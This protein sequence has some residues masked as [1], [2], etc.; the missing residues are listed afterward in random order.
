MSILD[1]FCSVDDF[2]QEF[3]PQWERHLLTQGRQRQRQGEMC[4][5]EML[6]ILI[7]FHFSGMRNFKQY[8]TQYVA[9]WLR[10]EFPIQLSYSRLLQV[11]PSLLTP[12]TVYLSQQM[13][14]CTGLNF[15]DSTSLA[16]C[17][18]ARIA[19]H[20]VFATQAARGKTSIGW[21]FGFKLHLV[22]NDQGE[23]LAFRLTPGNCDDRR[24]VPHLLQGLFGKVFADKGYISQSLREDLWRHGLQ[25]ITRV[26]KNMG[27]ILMDL[28]DK[29]LLRKRALIESVYDHL[30]NLCQ[31]EHTRH[32]SPVNFLVNLVCGLIAYSHLPHKP[33]LHIDH[34]PVWSL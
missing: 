8:Y 10:R 28:T 12:L 19:A 14:T 29:L 31:I 13:G 15:L 20:R 9:H 7:Y 21:F 16:V 1:L 30:K 26:R 23:L 27:N 3:A 2:W 4:P 22:I 24:P 17:H 11:V 33:S 5:S 18:P 32:R 25:M 34:T 6:T